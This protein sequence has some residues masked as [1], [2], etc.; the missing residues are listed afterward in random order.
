V[1][2]ERQSRHIK[3]EALYL[4]GP[5]EERSR[6][7]LQSIDCVLQAVDLYVAERP[8]RVEPVRRR[9]LR[10]LLDLREQPLPELARRVLPVPV[11]RRREPRVV[12]VRLRRLLLPELGLCA[13]V[14]TKEG[15]VLVTIR[16]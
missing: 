4:A 13:D 8:R 14:G 6:Q 1:D 2:E 5:V 11:E 9:E 10:R 15:F 12:P 16:L 7:R 3:R